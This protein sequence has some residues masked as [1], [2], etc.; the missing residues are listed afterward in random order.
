M[1]KLLS[2]ELEVTGSSRRNNLL[3][4][5]RGRLHTI[6]PKWPKAR[7]KLML[8]FYCVFLSE[9][10]GTRDN[11]NYELELPL[12]SLVTVMNA[13]DNFCCENK[14]GEGGF[15]PVYKVITH[16]FVYAIHIR[17]SLTTCSEFHSQ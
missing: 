9:V 3:Q 11:L 7:T 2:C 16:L 15:G 4:K 17:I 8:L 6:G 13:T 1:L 5:C 12:F 14:L 10:A